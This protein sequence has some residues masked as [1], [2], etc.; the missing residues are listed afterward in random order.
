[1][2]GHALR[3]PTRSPAPGQTFP[4]GVG[5]PR[6]VPGQGPGSG[7]S[8]GVRELPTISALCSSSRGRWD[9]GVWVDLTVPPSEFNVTC[10]GRSRYVVVTVQAHFLPLTVCFF[11]AFWSAASDLLHLRAKRALWSMVSCKAA[12]WL[13]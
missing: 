2:S 5:F 7:G 6:A 9:V 4:L 11:D 13:W 10:S 3:E 1:M 12:T 8:T